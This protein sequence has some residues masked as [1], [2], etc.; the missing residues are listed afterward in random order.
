MRRTSRAPAHRVGRLATARLGDWVEINGWQYAAH[1]RSMRA[2]SAAPGI[3]VKAVSGV[4]K[5]PAPVSISEKQDPK[6]A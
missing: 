1:S 5:A 4:K 6:P 3:N 2:L